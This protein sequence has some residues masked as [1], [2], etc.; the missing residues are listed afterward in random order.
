MFVREKV[1]FAAL[2]T[3]MSGA[4]LNADHFY[5][6]FTSRNAFKLMMLDMTFFTTSDKVQS[7]LH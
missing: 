2:Y 5:R 1:V 4:W 6:V 7:D 3:S